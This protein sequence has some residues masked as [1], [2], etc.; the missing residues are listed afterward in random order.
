MDLL[1]SCCSEPS[2]L[3]YLG[4]VLISLLSPAASDLT[5]ETLLLEDLRTELFTVGMRAP[6]SSSSG[7]VGGAIGRDDDDEFRIGI[8]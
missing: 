7:G 4:Q 1:D 6:R 2:F 3:T 5:T 8:C